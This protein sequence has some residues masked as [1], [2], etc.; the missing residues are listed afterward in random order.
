MD[1]QPEAQHLL[2]A[3]YLDW[4]SA[5]IAERLLALSPDEIYVLAARLHTRGTVG[6]VR[7]APSQPGSPELPDTLAGDQGP[8][9][10]LF[11]PGF[12]APVEPGLILVLTKE[13]RA[14]LDLPTFDVWAEWYR[15]DPAAYERDLFGFGFK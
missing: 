5:R 7:G 9:H 4:C 12:E 13:L 10:P 8:E 11:L 15:A 2:R 14:E 6:E 3:K 1:A